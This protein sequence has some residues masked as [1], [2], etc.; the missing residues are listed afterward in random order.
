MAPIFIQQRLGDSTRLTLRKI[1]LAGLTVAKKKIMHSWFA[2]E[3]PSIKEW[4]N[5]FRDMALIESSLA[6]IYFN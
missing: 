5:H 3:P 6:V 2:P 4:L 1:I